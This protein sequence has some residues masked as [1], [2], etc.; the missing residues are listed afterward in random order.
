MEQNNSRIGIALSGGGIRAAIFHLGVLKYMSQVGLFDRIANISSVSGASLCVGTIFAANGNIWPNGRTFLKTVL[1]EVCSRILGNDIQKSA[2]LRLPVSPRYWHNKVGLIAKMLEKKWGIT[3]TLQDISPFPYWEIN[4]TAFETGKN[5]RFR[6]DFMGGYNLGYV[7]KP[8]L[9]ISHMIA[10]SAGFPVLIG[11]YIL[12]TKGLRWTS[13]K[14]G[15]GKEIQ[16]DGKYTL[17]DGGVYDNLGLEALYKIGK[18][19]DSEID[20]LMVSNASASIAHKKHKSGM[21]VGNMLR[22]LD[23]SS[24]QV[25]ALR[26]REINAAVISKG[27]GM[28]L[29]IGNSADEIARRLGIPPEKSEYLV[30]TCISKEQAA[31][32]RDYATTLFTPSPKNF[33]LIL[34]HGYENAKCVHL[35]GKD[36]KKTAMAGQQLMC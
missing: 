20:C 3:G 9:P 36:S 8:Q 24:S 31:N 33:E 21:S 13:D 7:Q 16:A 29:K 12:K 1:P 14:W 23:I 15:K 35:L 11:P 17:W 28:Y 32:V 27:N 25:V 4:C 22:L 5:F 30:K 19:L 26:T 2:L 34:R 18:G 6:R 10:A